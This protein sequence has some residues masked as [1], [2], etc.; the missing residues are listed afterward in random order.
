MEPLQHWADS[1]PECTWGASTRVS[2][3]PDSM[4]FKPRKGPLR[5][6]FIL[7]SRTLSQAWVQAL[8]TQR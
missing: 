5:S 3:G 1:G 4:Y 8:G 2:L 7:G 6:R